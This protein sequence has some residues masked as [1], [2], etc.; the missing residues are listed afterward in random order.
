MCVSDYQLHVFIWP[1]DEN[2]V[3]EKCRM[4]KIGFSKVQRNQCSSE[5]L[6][7]QSSWMKGEILHRWGGGGVEACFL[8]SLSPPLFCNISDQLFI[9]IF[10]FNL[11]S[12]RAKKEK[13]RRKRKARPSVR[14]CSDLWWAAKCTKHLNQRNQGFEEK[15]IWVYIELEQSWRSTLRWWLPDG[16]SEGF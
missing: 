15:G 14:V 1:E 3:Y 7:R 12:K 6:K 10:F 9:L 16:S 13:S 4:D 8:F 2:D 11:E 5:P